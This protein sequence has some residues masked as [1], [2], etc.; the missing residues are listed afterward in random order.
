MA[1]A[2]GNNTRPVVSVVIPA[3]NAEDFVARALESVLDQS[4]TEIEVV[5]VDD[6]S[7]DETA[8]IVGKF[9]RRDSRVS[10]LQQS[11]A[12]VAAARNL[13]IRHAKG[14]LIA[15]LDADDVLYPG[16]I[17]RRAQLLI[18]SN[19]G[20]GMVYA[21]S[22]DI[23]EFGIP[24]GGV[25]VS[26]IQGS[27]LNTLIAHNF[28]G[29]AS[30]CLIR[31][32][33]FERVGLYDTGLNARG[34]QGCEDWDL[35]LRIAEEYEIGVVQEILVGY[36]KTRSSMSRNFE[37]MA[38][39]HI[40]IMQKL[41]DRD[42][43]IRRFLYRL[44]K[45]NLYIYFAN[46]SNQINDSRAALYWLHNALK[47]EFWLPLVRI[48]CYRLLVSAVWRQCTGSLPKFSVRRRPVEGSDE[49]EKGRSAPSYSRKLIVLIKLFA[50]S[51]LHKFIKIS[52]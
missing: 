28:I 7:E 6:G 36:R 23:D 21:W 37:R 49:A 19:V 43:A 44:S 33:C 16:S 50:G 32:C 14:E 10:L 12:G 8:A 15:P 35:Y 48:S 27:V 52:A 18:E 39:S 41:Q 9:A 13:G 20:L 46:Q 34:V 40:A 24:T 25:C 42:P 2:L 22:E 4:W 11:N 5:V 26:N 51:L 30:A 38:Q 31:R 29:N 3:F 17:E 45:S 1:S 47:A